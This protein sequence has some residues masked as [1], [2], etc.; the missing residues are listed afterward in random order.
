V[1][2]RGW[3]T[4]ECS[5]VEKNKIFDFKIEVKNVGKEDLVIT[6][7]SSSCGCLEVVAAEFA[8]PTANNVGA[9]FIAPETNGSGLMNQ[10][11]TDAS[12]KASFAA[13][14]KPNHSIYIT[15]RVDTNKVGGEFEK[16]IHVLSNDPENKDVM[17]KVRGKVLNVAAPSYGANNGVSAPQGAAATAVSTFSPH[18]FAA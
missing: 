11:P 13:T 14:I 7:V 16:M 12:G 3:G 4:N 6:S 17:W 18:C 10:T 2:R 1:Q 8:L 15:A 5:E 9:Q